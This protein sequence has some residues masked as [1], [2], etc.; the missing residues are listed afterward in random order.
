M[1]LGPT[2]KKKSSLCFSQSLNLRNCAHS[3]FKRKPD[4]QGRVSQQQAGL[5][6]ASHKAECRRER[7]AMCGRHF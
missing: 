7:E 3:E 6:T 5:F 1:R 2:G 4:E